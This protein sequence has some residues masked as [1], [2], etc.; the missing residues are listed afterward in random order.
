MKSDKPNPLSKISNTIQN[1]FR[2]N[3]E[4]GSSTN[5]FKPLSFPIGNQV[6]KT[7][8]VTA[9]TFEGY[10]PP[11]LSPKKLS[12]PG[13]YTPPNISKSSSQNSIASFNKFTAPPAPNPY[14]SG[15]N[16][17]N[18]T[19]NLSRNSS[20]SLPYSNSTYSA[21]SRA[22]SFN[23]NNSSNRDFGTARARQLGFLSAT[24]PISSGDEGVSNRN[25]MRNRF[26]SASSS[27]LSLNA[28]ANTNDSQVRN[29]LLMFGR[30]TQNRPTDNLSDVGS[31]SSISS[32]S[33]IRSFGSNS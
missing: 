13:A 1:K 26:P 2:P 12:S 19:P 32:R 22:N 18:I 23:S 28:Q 7:G 5:T 25:F 16:T 8:Q 11:N 3:P 6:Q 33:S 4:A 14:G 15:N 29:N 24:E 10:K 21:P 27:T 30:Q 17:N 9:S 31:N 20:Y